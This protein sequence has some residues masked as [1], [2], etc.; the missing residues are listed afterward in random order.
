VAALGER[1]EQLHE[2]LVLMKG[3]A[4]L[5]AAGSAKR[6]KV[7]KRQQ[8]TGHAVSRGGSSVRAASAPQRQ[9]GA[10][11]AQVQR[12]QE[13]QQQQ[14][15][16]YDAL[17]EA[18]LSSES[19]GLSAVASLAAHEA[20]CAAHVAVQVAAAA[21]ASAAEPAAGS[22]CRHDD[23]LVEDSQAVNTAATQSKPQVR[24]GGSRTLVR[25][26]IPGIWDTLAFS[27][28]L[29]HLSRIWG[30]ATACTS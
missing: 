14:Q 13:Q 25:W 24:L 16:E 7:A 19:S 11:L 5:A 20:P 3:S 18:L 22:G 4:A 12:Q 17:A 8:P 29:V 6:S 1:V 10:L 27:E 9:P 28:Y 30:H 21:A 26:C 15:E 23:Q 2:Q